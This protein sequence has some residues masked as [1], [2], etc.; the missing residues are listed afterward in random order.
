MQKKTNTQYFVAHQ[1][2]LQQLQKK[3]TTKQQ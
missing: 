1:A 3:A 2:S